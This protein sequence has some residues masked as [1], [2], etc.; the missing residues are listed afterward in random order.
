MYWANFIH[1]YQPP[2]QTEEITRRV[3]DECYRKLVDI[4]L[5]HPQARV[6]LNINA[7]LTEQLDKYGLH[8]IINGLRTLAERGQIE[9]TGSAMYHPILP[10]IPASEMRRQV[11]LNTEVNRRYFG[12]VY[13][14]QGFFPPEMCYSFEVAQVLAEMGFRWV[15]GD[16][17]AYDGKLGR[18]RPDRVY[19]LEGL[20]EFYFFFKERPVSAGLTYGRF[21]TAK[22]LLDHLGDRLQRREYLLTG[23]DGEIYGHHRPGQ[24]QLLEEVYEENLLPTCTVSELPTLFPQVETVSPLSSSWST[25]E[26]EMAAGAPYSHWSYPGNELHELQWEL[27]NLVVGAF[28]ASPDTGVAGPARAAL[29]QGLHSC[30]YWW[31]SCRPWWDT[32]MIERGA[33]LLLDAARRAAGVLPPETLRRAEALHERIVTTARR[34]QESGH[35]RRLREEYLREHPQVD[36]KQLTF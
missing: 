33:D 5:R 18:Y 30:Q 9:L 32:G 16:E 6:T 13:A 20:K 17:I 22:K 3:A 27:T 2:T 36:A 25:W 8:D 19:R 35:A 29:D 24:E 7:C 28:A 15:I 14:P 4:L 23:T 34:W 26:D 1:I 12:D 10:L 11:E 21:P 31:A